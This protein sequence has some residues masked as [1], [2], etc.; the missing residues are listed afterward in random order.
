MA[1]DFPA[2]P[3]VG[4]TFT[5]GSLVY[6]F[7]GTKW[8]AEPSGVTGGTKIE[9][10]NTKAEVTDTGSNGT[11]AVTTEG[12]QRLSV[13][14]SG[15]VAVDTNTLYVD[16]ANNRVGI[17]T[18]GPSSALEV[19]SD[20][21][22]QFK[23]G[24]ASNAARAS[25]LHNGSDAYLDTTAG[26][27][28]FRTNT[29]T[30]RARIDSLGR[31]L[32]G[33]SSIGSNAGSSVAVVKGANL[34]VG[35]GQGQLAVLTSNA[36]AADVGG[37]I[38]LGGQSTQADWSYATIAGRS[39][40][41]GYA[42]YFAIGTSTAA[43]AHFERL[44]IDSSGRLLVGTSTAQS[45]TRSQ[46]SKFTVQGNNQ[47]TSDGAQVNLANNTNAAGLSSGDTLGQIIFTDNGPGE[48]GKIACQ[49]DATPGTNDYP[50]R[51]V[52]STTADG[53]SSPT[54]RMRITNHG[55]V[56]MVS[57]IDTLY[58]SSVSAA[59]T[60]Y[61]LIEGRHSGTAGAA[62]SGTT[63]FEVFTNGNVRNTNNSYGQISDVKLKE[64]IVD[65]NSQWDDLK[66]V[67]VRNFNFKEGQTHRQIGV[68][69]QELELVSPGLVS[70]TPDRDAEG[71]DLGTVTKGVNYSVLYM[72]AVKALQEAMERIE[73]L[74]A[75][76]AALEAA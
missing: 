54:E 1:I 71:N 51:L 60:T 40:N 23:V 21:T 19:A 32:C 43:G 26:G 39:E 58:V 59:G 29:S 55:A 17:G 42:G 31:L 25:L 30:E 68:I 72:K 74:E 46:Y 15:N 44:R 73:T 41:N 66:A 67:R 64:N 56:S 5:A 63:S 57:A 9:V 7:D 45:G 65:A 20:G 50:G 53:A 18:T 10:G 49:V 27:L 69:A 16:A 52:F 3:T 13:D 61:R 75:K 24:M 22:P 35:T 12:T 33:T 38:L 4:Q 76:V 36:Q 8:T 37:S 6:T 14:A 34:T 11:F 2:T 47:S 28:V 62:F 70:E 48:Y